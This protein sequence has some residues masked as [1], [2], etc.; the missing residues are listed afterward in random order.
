M[1]TENPKKWPIFILLFGG[2]FVLLL[3][4]VGWQFGGEGL[5]TVVKYFLLF[6]FLLLIIALVIVAILWLFKRHK[7]EMVYIMRNAII[8]TCRLN[9]V[10]YKQELWLY[11]S[12]LPLPQPRKLGVV[13]GFAMIK[14]AVKKMYDPKQKALVEMDKPKDVIFCAFNDGGIISKILGQYNI[15][16]GIYPDDFEFEAG[17][18][19]LMASTV[20]VNDGGFGLSP[21]LFKMLWCQK[22]WRDTHLIEETAKEIIHRYL[23]EDNLNEIAEVIHKAIQVEPKAKDDKSYG[24]K[25]GLDKKIP[26]VAQ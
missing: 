25:L 15:F 13:T 23:I 18:G 4:F 14:A 6:G 3:V 9:K 16:A 1:T 7:K 24:E 11:G 12:G 20:Y 5:L 2:A 26:I 22:H 8:S 21:Q 19:D 17:V 10:N